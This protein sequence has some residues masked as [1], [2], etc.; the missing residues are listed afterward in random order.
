M[1]F[2]AVWNENFRFLLRSYLKSKF[3]LHVKSLLKVISMLLSV[4]SVLK[5]RIFICEKVR[6]IAVLNDHDCGR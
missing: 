6:C 3:L 5:S 2:I 4:A 1:E